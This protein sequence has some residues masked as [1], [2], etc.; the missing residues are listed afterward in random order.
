M[1]ISILLGVSLLIL[2][3]SGATTK[4]AKD[5]KEKQ[6]TANPLEITYENAQ[7]LDQRKQA[8]LQ[9][10]KKVMGDLGGG[11]TGIKITKDTA[12]KASHT[13]NYDVTYTVSDAGKFNAKDAV[14]QFDASL[15][16]DPI[17]GVKSSMTLVMRPE[18]VSADVVL[19]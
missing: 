9:R 17:A 16:K 4:P 3:A 15:Q 5:A 19:D 2:G 18:S 13:I 1:L 14:S 6:L 8:V 10:W 11:A 7:V 12:S